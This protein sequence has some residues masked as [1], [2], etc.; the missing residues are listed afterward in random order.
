MS[1]NKTIQAP[2][3]P[4]A[5]VI[6]TYAVTDK[7]TGTIWQ[8]DRNHNASSFNNHEV[9]RLIADVMAKVQAKHGINDITISAKKYIALLVS[10]DLGV[11]IDHNEMTAP[12]PEV[13]AVEPIAVAQIVA[14]PIQAVADTTEDDTSKW[15]F[16]QIQSGK[17]E[18]QV[19]QDLKTAGWTDENLGKYFKVEEVVPLPPQ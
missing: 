16:A 10:N 12:M 1:E 6:K 4:K 17:T 9:V 5:Q 2:A 15:I 14:E 11:V 3:Q 18:V 13:K 7:K 19:K 8:A